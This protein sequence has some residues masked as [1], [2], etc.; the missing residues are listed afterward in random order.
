MIKWSVIA[1]AASA[2]SGGNADKNSR[3]H[4][5][6]IAVYGQMFLGCAMKFL[7]HKM[8]Y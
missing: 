7:V 3:S 8:K 2:I 4:L 5:W 6:H 1:I